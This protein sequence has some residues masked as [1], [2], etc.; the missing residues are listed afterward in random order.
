MCTACSKENA[1]LRGKAGKAEANPASQGHTCCMVAAGVGHL[2][3]TSSPLPFGDLCDSEG[4]D[5]T[6]FSPQVQS[7][8][9]NK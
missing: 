5:P 2:P 4:A 1:G 8:M 9:E 7:V 3:R 6:L